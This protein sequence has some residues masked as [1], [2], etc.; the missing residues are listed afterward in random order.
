LEDVVA[1]KKIYEDA[2]K[3]LAGT[4]GAILDAYHT[5]YYE[6]IADTMQDVVAAMS[7]VF[8]AD[9]PRFDA[10]KFDVAVRAGF[11]REYDRVTG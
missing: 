5:D 10:K 7:V 2:V 3:A 1:S 9:N 6:C 4:Y 8:A 11:G